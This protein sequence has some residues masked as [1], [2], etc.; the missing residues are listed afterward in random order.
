MVLIFFHYY[1]LPFETIDSK[2]QFIGGNVQLSTKYF[3]YRI[4]ETSD[5]KD[6][7]VYFEK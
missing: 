5:F 1:Y 6:I 3:T 2:M 7:T 4:Y